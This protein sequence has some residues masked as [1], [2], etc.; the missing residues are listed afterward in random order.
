MCLPTS[1]LDRLIAAQDSYPPLPAVVSG[2]VATE[3]VDS[4][5]P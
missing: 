1:E 3:S 2:F 4:V 5:P